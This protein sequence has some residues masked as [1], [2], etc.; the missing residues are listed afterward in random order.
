M[1]MRK[2]KWAEPELQAC[3]WRIDDPDAHRGQWRG[4]FS[5]DRP[6]HVELGCGKGVSTAQMAYAE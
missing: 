1:R 5:E 3:P 4:L 6:L 2:K